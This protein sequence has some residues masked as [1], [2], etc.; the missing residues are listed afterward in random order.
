MGGPP[1]PRNFEHMTTSALPRPAELTS[2]PHSGLSVG[3]FYKMHFLAAMLPLAAGLMLFGWRA[4]AAVML[5]CGGAAAGIAIWRRIGSRG[6]QLSYSHGLWLA[7][8]LA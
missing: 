7:L 8:L 1:M 2:L 3:D 5:V 4:A 6:R